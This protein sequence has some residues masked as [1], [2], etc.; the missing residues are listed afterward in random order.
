LYGDGNRFNAHPVVD[1][2]LQMLLA[3]N[4]SL[5]GANANVSQQELD[6]FKFSASFVANTGAAIPNPRLCRV[7]LTMIR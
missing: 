4:V 7:D 2:I 6:L 3:T 1:G 5:C